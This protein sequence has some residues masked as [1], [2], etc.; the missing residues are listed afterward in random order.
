MKPSRNLT[1][2][3]LEKVMVHH[4]AYIIP[5]YIEF[6]SEHKANGRRWQWVHP[7]WFW[8]RKRRSWPQFSGSGCQQNLR[9]SPVF[10]SFGDKNGTIVSRTISFN[11]FE[12]P[13]SQFQFR[14][15]FQQVSEMSPDR[16]FGCLS[17]RMGFSPVIYQNWMLK[18]WPFWPGH[19][20][21]SP[22]MVFP[23]A[24]LLRLLRP[25]AVQR[26][27]QGGHRTDDAGGRDLQGRCRPPAANSLGFWK[28]VD[29]YDLIGPYIYI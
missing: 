10:I 14:H 24:Q 27:H 20:Y 6:F 16:N 11:W 3:D 7:A 12:H 29:C 8:R 23:G 18:K 1:F 4:I 19:N 5:M 13:T 22:P 2:V 21:R 28:G 9:K 25:A 15:N 26:S 17:K